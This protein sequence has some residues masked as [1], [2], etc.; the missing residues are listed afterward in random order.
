MTAT[1]K[2][3]VNG[4]TGATTQYDGLEEGSLAEVGKKSLTFNTYS[5]DG[6]LP[7]RNL[8]VNVSEK[9]PVQGM[10][11]DVAYE[12]IN[13]NHITY[14]ELDAKFQSHTWSCPGKVTFTAVTGKVHRFSF[15]ATCTG[16]NDGGVTI[17]GTGVGVTK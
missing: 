2:D 12:P 6:K 5:V 15:F 13:G 3:P 7:R 14:Q 11:Y 8:S 16:G 10:T 1:F 17:T 4:Y 9:A